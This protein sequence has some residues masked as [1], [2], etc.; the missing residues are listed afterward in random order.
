MSQLSKRSKKLL[1]HGILQDLGGT[2]PHHRLRLD[3]DLFARLRIPAEARLPMRLDHAADSGNHKFSS[4]TLGFLDGK[5]VKFLEELSDGLLRCADL[6]GDMRNDFGLAHWLGCHFVLLIL[7]KC[8]SASTR[9]EAGS[10]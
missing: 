9:I 5:L 6:F 1:Q 4:S 3:L 7:L 2:Q 8:L 10:S